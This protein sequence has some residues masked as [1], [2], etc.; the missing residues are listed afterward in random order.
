VGIEK[1]Y[2]IKKIN[3]KPINV[4]MLATLPKQAP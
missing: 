2:G 1:M 4:A 3:G